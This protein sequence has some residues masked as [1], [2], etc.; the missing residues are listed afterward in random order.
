[1]FPKIHDF[2]IVNTVYKRRHIIIGR[3]E[4]LLQTL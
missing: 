1:M 4:I 3:E 2:Q